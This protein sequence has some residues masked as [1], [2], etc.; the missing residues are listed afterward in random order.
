M[1]RIWA[2]KFID[3]W[4]TSARR[5]RLAPFKRFAGMIA[6]HLDGILTWCDLRVSNGAVEG[7]NNKVKAVSHRSYGFRT[8]ENYTTAIWHGRADRG[9]PSH[10]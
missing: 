8:T 10:C 7:M 3:E 4:L 6:E 5:S 1:D 9:C 2:S